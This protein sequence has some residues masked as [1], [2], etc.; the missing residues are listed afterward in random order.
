MLSWFNNLYIIIPGLIFILYNRL[1][2]I[3]CVVTQF[4]VVIGNGIEYNF[5]DLSVNINACLLALI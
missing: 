2:F 1:P 5:D 3:I 4:G